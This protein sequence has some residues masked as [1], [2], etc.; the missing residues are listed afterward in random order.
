MS[1]LHLP[2]LGEPTSVGGR[3]AVRHA[4]TPRPRG[5]GWAFVCATPAGVAGVAQTTPVCATPT[6]VG[7]RRA[8]CLAA[9]LRPCWR[10][11]RY[12]DGASSAL[13]CWCWEDQQ[14]VVRRQA[15]WLVVGACQPGYAT[16]KGMSS[17]VAIRDAPVTAGRARSFSRGCHC[18]PKGS[19]SVTHVRLRLSCAIR[20]FGSAPGTPQERA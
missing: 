2:V 17:P 6:S 12:W 11:T 1:A 14:S 5:L 13:P 18:A 16:G 10:T 19:T 4:M 9:T 20:K 8:V 7:C 15:V 3:L